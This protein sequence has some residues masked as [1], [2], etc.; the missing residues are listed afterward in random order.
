MSY[1][2]DT[3]QYVWEGRP[4]MET[5]YFTAPDKQDSDKQHV[6]DNC[7][8]TWFEVWIENGRQLCSYCI[9]DKENE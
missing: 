7:G 3:I 1:S 5:S 6:C 9:T 8:R 4:K 2:D